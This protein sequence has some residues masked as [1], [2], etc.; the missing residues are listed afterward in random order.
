SFSVRD[1]QQK[2]L[3]GNEAVRGGSQRKPSGRKK[4]VSISLC[5]LRNGSLPCWGCFW[6]PLA[7]VSLH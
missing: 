1:K 3:G 5:G 4:R 7:T 2:N 6:F